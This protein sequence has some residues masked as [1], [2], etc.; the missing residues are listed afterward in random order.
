MRSLRYA[1]IPFGST[2]PTD[3]QC[4][5]SLSPSKRFD[6]LSETHQVVF[7]FQLVQ[8]LKARTLV[9]Q[10]DVGAVLSTQHRWQ[11]RAIGCKGRIHITQVA[12]AV[13]I[14]QRALL[15][16]EL[17]VLDLHDTRFRLRATLYHI[18]VE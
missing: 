16:P 14:F 7:M 6:G 15:H 4:N 18:T 5:V 3:R 2:D 8:V 11:A 17:P 10:T 9:E 1:L 13:R 12:I